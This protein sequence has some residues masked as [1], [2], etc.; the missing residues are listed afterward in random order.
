[1][2]QAIDKARD[3]VNNISVISGGILFAMF[4]HLLGRMSL[5]LFLSLSLWLGVMSLVL[6]SQS[7]VSHTDH[8][9]H[10]SVGS[11]LSHPWESAAR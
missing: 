2:T 1:M 4:T 10:R 6:S 7:F 9:H 8:H 3:W 11:F 5:S